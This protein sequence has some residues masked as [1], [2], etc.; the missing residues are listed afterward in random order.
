MNR[1]KVNY[2]KKLYES[3]ESII[4]DLEISKKKLGK[5]EYV[6]KLEHYAISRLSMPEKITVKE[7]GIDLV[8]FNKLNGDNSK[9]RTIHIDFADAIAYHDLQC[10]INKKN[11]K[12]DKMMKPMID[13]F[14]RMYEEEE[15]EKKT[16]S[17]IK[18][19][20]ERNRRYKERK[21]AQLEKVV[22]EPSKTEEESKEVIRVI[23]STE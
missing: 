16:T 5:K 23:V 13:A 8:V 11:L 20:Q 12:P 15:N 9:R 22:I 17:I 4:V 3:K 7:D 10:N 14:N 19:K 18:N 21:K 6:K 1:F 2:M